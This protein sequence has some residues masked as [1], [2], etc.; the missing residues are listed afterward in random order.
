MAATQAWN[1]D[2]ADPSHWFL[3][4]AIE[5]PVQLFACFDAI[6]S[7]TIPSERSPSD[8]GPLLPLPASDLLPSTV[9]LFFEPGP[10]DR[11]SVDAAITTANLGS[12]LLW[13]GFHNVATTALSTQ[14]LGEVQQ[15]QRDPSQ[16]ADAALSAFVLGYRSVVLAGG[17]AVGSPAAT[18]SS[19]LR[20]EITVVT[21]DGSVDPVLF[22][23]ALAARMA[24]DQAALT[25]TFCDLVGRGWPA[26]ESL[27]DGLTRL[28]P[29]AVLLALARD[30]G[31]PLD[32]IRIA[33]KAL[34]W[35]RLLAASGRSA[36]SPFQFVRDDFMNPFA[37]EAVVE[38]FL[39][40]PEPEPAR[41]DN[42]PLPEPPAPY[43]VNLN[44][45]RPHLVII[46]P[47]SH[48]R[49][50]SVGLPGPDY[51]C[52]P[53]GALKTK[54]D[55]TSPASLGADAWDGLLFLV[56]GGR[57]LGWY[58]WASYTGKKYEDAGAGN[59]ADSR[60]I[61]GNRQY[62]FVGFASDD[63]SKN[64]SLRV[65]D[66]D[67]FAD[68]VID[69]ARHYFRSSLA[70]STQARVRLH[71]GWCNDIRNALKWSGSAGC[72][73]SPSY[74]A[75]RSRLIEAYS[76]DHGLSAPLERVRVAT[77]QDQSKKLYGVDEVEAAWGGAISGG[78][79]L[80]HPDEP[81]Q[82]T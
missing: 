14:L 38:Y 15:A 24:A 45:G 37:L 62:F 27:T 7:T 22:F 49:L 28:Y 20:V 58:R 11:E 63:A 30:G 56:Y 36:E 82:K 12:R 4:A 34:Y 47:F 41:P 61:A 73:V 19:D 2:D 67:A 26:V 31:A 23:S 78:L 29:T 39:G 80:V 52:N 81:T 65:A 76:D 3:R 40:W 35:P 48:P 33:Q 59:C 8:I 70:V 32:H 10:A 17:Q 9:S 46:E 75:M 54:C 13:V 25:Q 77:T 42:E 79:W 44:D 1:S 21:D 69:G 74:Y 64:M 71:H 51:R 5:G 72:L 68:D 53:V 16:T 57:V 60:S 43:R 18:G 6:V 66:D 50:G 55:R